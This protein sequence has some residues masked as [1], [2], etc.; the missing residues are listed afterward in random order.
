MNVLAINSSPNKDRGNT[1]LLLEPFLEGMRTAGAEVETVY[2]RDMDIRPCTGE[3]ACWFAHPG[4][5]YQQDDMQALYPKIRAAEVWVFAAPLYFWGMPGPM[6][7][8][9]DRMMPLGGAKWE[10]H[11]GRLVAVGTKPPVPGHVVLVSSGGLWDLT[12]FD[13]LVAHVREIAACVDREFAG[14][15]LRPESNVLKPMLDAG[16]PLG[17]ILDAAREAGRQLVTQG[18]IDPTTL[19]TVARPLMPEDAYIQSVN[20]AFAQILAA[21][22][23]AG[24]ERVA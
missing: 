16:A 1:A 24:G 6:K 14:A 5:C 18:S 10:R 17:D 9:V 22:R 3:V 12:I 15:L 2:T 21:Q 11:H 7:N 8:L 23:G 4:E 19:E 20:D 13:P